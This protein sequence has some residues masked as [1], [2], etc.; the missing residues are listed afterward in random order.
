MG[1]SI[2][3]TFPTATT[4]S[5]TLTA[6]IGGATQIVSRN[7]ISPMG[8]QI[9]SEFRIF[10]FNAGSGS[11]RD[12]FFNCLSHEIDFLPVELIR[13][14]GKANQ[15]DIH[16]SW[17]TASEINNSHFEVERSTNAKIWKAV[18]KVYGKGN[19]LEEVNYEFIDQTALKG[20]NYYRL[21]QVDFDGNHEFSEVLTVDFQ[22]KSSKDI[23]I[24]PTLVENELTIVNAT[25]HATLYNF[26]GQ[27]MSIFQIS[28]ELFT[29]NTND[30]PSGRYTLSILSDNRSITSL[31]FVKE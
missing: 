1:I 20:S 15:E 28:E 9:I 24:Y 31:S 16:L 22:T 2:E 18:G 21:R 11:T 17:T 30:L 26:S 5:V 6:I 29:L 7:L 8:G 4:Y 3:I 13:F 10:N 25:G 12:Q 27:V 19:S 23:T 14:N